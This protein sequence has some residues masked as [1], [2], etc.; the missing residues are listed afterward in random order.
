MSLQLSNN[1]FLIGG[2]GAGKTTIGRKLA[3]RLSYTFYDSDVEIEQRTGAA[4]SWIFELEGEAGF[5]QRE[6]QMIKELTAKNNI[7]LAT[8]GGAILDPKNR[9]LLT[10]RGTVVY[11]KTALD[12]QLH[13]V[14]KDKRRPLLQVD[15]RKEVLSNIM[16]AREPLYLSIADI[17]VET[18]NRGISSVINSILKKVI[19]E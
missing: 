19:P 17:V 10:S 4:I 11:L 16:Q 6:H 7:I 9:D 18:G 8:G 13:R 15:N 1:I 14:S 3:E 2:M 12:E 5:R